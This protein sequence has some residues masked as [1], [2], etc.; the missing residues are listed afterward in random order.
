MFL[1]AL[2]SKLRNKNWFK[3]NNINEPDILNFLDLVCLGT[4]CDVVPVIGLNRAI[5]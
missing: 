3:L 5:S 4:I 2:N 1:V